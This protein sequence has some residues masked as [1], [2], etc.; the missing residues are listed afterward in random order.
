MG[1]GH[2]WFSGRT[3]T[4]HKGDLGSISDQC[5]LFP[6]SPVHGS[7]LLG[8]LRQI[9]SF[10][11]SD[12][13]ERPPQWK[14]KEGNRSLTARPWGMSGRA[15]LVSL[16]PLCSFA[17]VVRKPAEGSSRE[18]L[19]TRLV[20]SRV[21]FQNHFCLVE[22]FN[23]SGDFFLLPTCSLEV[24]C[25]TSKFGAIHFLFWAQLHCGLQAGKHD[26]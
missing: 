9:S 22:I 18:S 4:S 12:A 14:Q 1:G 6:P 25:L 10:L 21:H 23:F 3:V 19:G 7:F 2:W 26:F 17:C 8:L 15:H 24:W 11:D 5:W 16:V 13:Q 20:C